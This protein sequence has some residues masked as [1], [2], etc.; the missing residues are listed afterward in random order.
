MVQYYV[1]AAF[2]G[3]AV[4]TAEIA[5]RY[6][7][8]PKKVIRCTWS[9]A[10]Y[11]F[12]ALLSVAAFAVL[13]AS[14]TV[15]NDSGNMDKL[16]YALLAGFGAM[17]L[18]R[19]KLFNVKTEAGEKVS[20]GPEYVVD[21]FLAVIDREI[22]RLRAYH[23]ADLVKTVMKDI[24]FTKAAIPLSTLMTNSMQNV[25]EAELK[26]FGRRIKEARDSNELSN[27]DKA[28]ALG[29]HILDIAGEEFLNRVFDKELRRIFT[30]S[31]TPPAVGGTP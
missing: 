8:E 22:D 2:C 14:G 12:N 30:L 18:L 6:K 7:D 17:V 20:I 3:F 10:Y 9:A 29:F 4:G 31:K 24:D 23:R 26:E 16:S 19:S 13:V 5:S 1:I 15:S 25:S 11:I 28:Y 21:T 27:Q